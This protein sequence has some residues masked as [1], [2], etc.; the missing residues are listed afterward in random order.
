MSKQEQQRQTIVYLWNEG[1][2]SGAEI[3]GFPFPQSMTI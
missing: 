3:H 2:Q 1:V